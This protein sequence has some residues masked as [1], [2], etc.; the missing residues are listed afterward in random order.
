MAQ[1]VPF[2]GLLA[3]I[4][5]LMRACACA[6]L[7]AHDHREQLG[8][9]RILMSDG[10]VIAKALNRTL[11]EFPM[12]NS[13]IDRADAELGLCDYW[14]CE[15]LCGRVKCFQYEQRKRKRKW[16]RWGELQ[17]CKDVRVH[18]GVMPINDRESKL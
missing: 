5:A 8:N 6:S 12:Q 11:V 9:N 1:T 15:S 3:S 7:L 16:G 4:H 10:L 18:T 17:I 14:E 2:S 13:R